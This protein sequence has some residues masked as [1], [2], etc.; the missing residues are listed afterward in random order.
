MRFVQF[1]DF[2]GPEVLT[3]ETGPIPAPGPGEVLVR[4]RATSINPVDIQLRRGDYSNEL[5]LPSKI[6]VDVAGAIEKIGPGVSRFG[7]GDEVFYVPRLLKNEGSYADYHVEQEA[8][9]AKK[10]ASLS[11]AEAAALPLA[12]GT[13][14]ECLIERAQ[15]RPGQRVLIHGGSG[16]VGVY[17]LQIA[18]GSGAFVATTCR[19]E[20]FDLVRRLGAQ[21]CFDYRD[22]NLY[23]RLSDEMAEGFDIILDTVGGK[24]IENSLKLLKPFGAVVSIVDQETPQN[25]IAGWTFNG[26]I[27]FVFTTQS[28]S[29]LD[30]LSNFVDRG[31]LRPVIERQYDLS[32]VVEAHRAVEGGAR[33][34]KVI[35]VTD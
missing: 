14:W 28:A 22:P 3:V 25:L 29:R 27:H 7:I 35:L 19:S 9:I 16:G 26:S 15:L 23:G 2:G 1:S 17:A 32:N 6:G 13:A 12:A 20:N 24:T 33:S 34:G 10:P 31:L 11:F 18:S 4:V 5:Q 30:Q 8:I 21:A